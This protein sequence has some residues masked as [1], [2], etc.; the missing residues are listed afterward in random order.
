V[1]IIFGWTDDLNAD[2][3]AS[4]FLNA[5]SSYAYRYVL[6]GS[7]SACVPCLLDLFLDYI[8]TTIDRRGNLSRFKIIFAILASDLFLFSYAIPSGAIYLIPSIYCAREIIFVIIVMA[9]LCKMQS[10]P[11]DCMS[12]MTIG[13]FL[14]VANL[15]KLYL[16]FLEISIEF[17]TILNTIVLII[18]IFATL[19]TFRVFLKALWSIHLKSRSSELT[20]HE[21][22]SVIYIM[23]TLFFL[24]GL[25]ILFPIAGNTTWQNTRVSWLL[26][27]SLLTLSFAII[28]TLLNGRLVRLESKK[29]KVSLKL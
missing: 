5:A 16:T 20:N 24:L 11:I 2:N 19:Y 23:S 21:K 29:T 25:W 6:L 27:Y 28:V 13:I 22:S 1:P 8:S 9:Y 12:T 18:Q 4:I 17:K 3:G 26:S 7:F 14:S 10:G 15:L